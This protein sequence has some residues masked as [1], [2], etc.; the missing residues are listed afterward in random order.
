M[1]ILTIKRV[2]IIP[3]CTL[4]VLMDELQIPICVTLENPWI[5]NKPMVSC[6]P[7]GQYICNV[8]DSPKYGKSFEVKEV[9]NRTHILFHKG[10]I[11]KNTKGCILL[12]QYFGFY[13]GEPAVLNSTKTVEY[14]HSL[15]NGEAFKL[16]ILT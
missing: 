13:K 6:I 4:G 1:K 2:S 14:F 11:E 8:I 3:K 10:N 5:D 15:M 9:P 16:N 12:G 7:S